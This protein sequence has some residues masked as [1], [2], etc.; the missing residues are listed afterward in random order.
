VISKFSQNIEKLVE[1]AFEKRTFPNFFLLRKQQ[2]I[3]WEI[4]TQTQAL[5]SFFWVGFCDVVEA[6]I[7]KTI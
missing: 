5:C 3:V 4:K 1:F 2:K 6:V 7:H